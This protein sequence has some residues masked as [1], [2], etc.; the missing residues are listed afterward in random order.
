MAARPGG[1]DKFTTNVKVAVRVRPFKS[2]EPAE[3]MI[4]PL[5]TGEVKGPDPALRLLPRK[6][7]SSNTDQKASIYTYD[8]VFW[9]NQKP[10]ATNGDIFE[11]VGRPCMEKAFRGINSTVFAY[12]QTASGKSYTMG[13][14]DAS[15]SDPGLITRTCEELFKT[16]KDG[17]PASVP[18]VQGLKRSFRVRCSFLEIYDDAMS[19]GKV[20]DLNPYADPTMKQLKDLRTG[21]ADL[22]TKSSG[23]LRAAE[24]KPL[25]KSVFPNADEEEIRIRLWWLYGY[26][27]KDMDIVPLKVV[28]FERQV[29]E[30]E[31][32]AQDLNRVPG[33]LAQTKQGLKYAGDRF[34]VPG[35]AEHPVSNTKEVSVLIEKG[36][37]R[38]RTAATNFN[39]HSSR[40]HAIVQFHVDVLYR[41]EED[42]TAEWEHHSTG[43]INFVDLAGS[44]RFTDRGS[45]TASINLSLM[46]LSRILDDLSKPGAQRTTSLFRSFV[47]TMLLYDSLGGSCETWMVACVNPSMSSYEETKST[48]NYANKT[49]DIKNVVEV[50]KKKDSKLASRIQAITDGLAAARHDPEAAA[51]AA[52]LEEELKKATMTRSLLESQAEADNQRMSEEQSRRDRLH[53][54]QKQ[55][56]D[57]YEGRLCAMETDIAER[58]AEIEHT[59]ALLADAAIATEKAGKDLE[60]KKE[61]NER[62]KHEHKE[63]LEQKLQRINADVLTTQERQKQIEAAIHDHEEDVARLDE[64]YEK[65]KTEL[66]GMQE[67]EQLL[68]ESVEALR[69]G[70]MEKKAEIAKKMQELEQMRKEA[71]AARK[72]EMAKEMEARRAEEALARQQVKLEEGQEELRSLMKDAEQRKADLSKL[73]EVEQELGTK[74]ADLRGALAKL[75]EERRN[76]DAEIANQKD[77]LQAQEENRAELREQIENGAEEMRQ[78]EL[79]FQELE[80]DAALNARASDAPADE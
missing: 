9:S 39:E 50:H 25:L 70:D 10:A 29:T 45:E 5:E 75:D 62:R 46:Q 71:D 28:E 16:H 78:M 22:A 35:L 33:L 60:A 77:T 73:E 30:A 47:L 61:E 27:A 64:E 20:K 42:D 66:V 24:L 65:A 49:R 44:E 11:T 1:E 53:L 8:S 2:D 43:V 19:G 15:K 3:P 69:N 18:P 72:Q 59:R 55:Q 26:S 40:S 52:Q 41:P 76:L 37:E 80:A 32:K 7:T 31:R 63:R 54:E 6:G 56:K 68:K 21:F 74:L 38:R 36:T 51:K 48:L 12:G 17:G 58:V 14:G 4:E 34:F 67:G 57:L 13:L 79:L 23:A